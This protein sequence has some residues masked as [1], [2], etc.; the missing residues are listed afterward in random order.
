MKNAERR[1]ACRRAVFFAGIGFVSA[2]AWS[3]TALAQ[4][5][6]LDIDDVLRMARESDPALRASRAHAGAADEQRSS[7]RGRLLPVISVYDE[8][9][10]WDSPFE[11]GFGGATVRARNEDTNTFTASL[12]QPLLG[13]LRRVQD[14]D[15][16]ASTAEAR[17]AGTRVV[18]AN[19][20]EALE[21]HYLRLFEAH[22]MQAIAKASQAELQQQVSSTQV[23]VAAGTLTKA[24]LLR[25]QVA[26]GNAQ[27]QEIVATTAQ[28]VARASLLS[29]IGLS[30]DDTSVEFKEP[31]RLLEQG[32]RSPSTGSTTAEQRPEIVQARLDAEAAH[33]EERSRFYALLPEVDLEAAYQRVDGQVFAPK[34]A[35]FIGVK[36]AWP[37]W[38]WG[39]T[40]A[41]HAAA[42]QEEVAAR[43]NVDGALRQVQVEL[44]SRRA[45][46]AAADHAVNLARDTVASAE[47]AYRVMDA[48]VRVGSGTT[49]DLLDSQSA[50]TQARLRLTHSEYERAISY[51]QLERASGG[52]ESAPA[53]GAAAPAP[54]APAPAVIPA[55]AP[56]T[57]PTSAVPAPAAPAPALPAAP[58]PPAKP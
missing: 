23:K 43:A 8:Y 28:T 37:I 33:H 39:S 34:N 6:S 27:Q 15:A 20:K 32:R 7:A 2:V 16:R 51:V 52:S 13:L 4:T 22:A 31:T 36:A 17:D 3:G 58:T 48:V 38:E 18:E 10:H 46:L 54:A 5:R 42:E 50:L 19:L 11:I 1:P 14:F 44:T 26:L 55:T 56:A 24:D 30:P 57:A 47:E 41:A 45:E 29:A 49:T 9:Q 25:V 35:A 40:Q 53:A 12:S 21:S